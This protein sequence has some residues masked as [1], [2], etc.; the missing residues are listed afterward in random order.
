VSPPAPTILVVEAEREHGEVLAEQL[1]ADGYRVELARTC[2]HARILARASRPAL[3]VLGSLDAPRGA[4]G[5]LQEIRACDRDGA[6]DPRLGAIV[7]G[8][9]ARETDLLRAFEVGADDFMARPARYLEL[10]ARVR[11]ILARLERGRDRPAVLE[12]GPLVL[13]SRS[14]SVTLHGEPVELRRLEFDLLAHLA[15]EPG[16]V[17]AKRELLSAVWGYRSG[18]STRTLD[19]HASRLRRK[20]GAR[21]EGWVINERGVGYRLR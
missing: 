13:D 18:G 20:L 19:S 8:G 15:G 5:L 2:E 11:A 16:R 4:I 10:R 6:W 21:G 14:R 3:A 7:V 12:V 1:L 17:F 9:A